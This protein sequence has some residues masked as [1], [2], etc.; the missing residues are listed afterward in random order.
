MASAITDIYYP[1]FERKR[2]ILQQVNEGEMGGGCYDALQPV[3]TGSLQQS[4]VSKDTYHY[5]KLFAREI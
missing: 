5:F 3:M 4:H 2:R 1:L